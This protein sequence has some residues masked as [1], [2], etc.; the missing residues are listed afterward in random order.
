ML[1]EHGVGE[2]DD[3]VALVYLDHVKGM[4]SGKGSAS[5]ADRRRPDSRMRYIR[6]NDTRQIRHLLNRQFLLL[7]RQQ[8]IHNH[9]LPVRSIT[10]QPQ[11]TQRLLRRSL[12]AFD[13]AEFVREFNEQLSVRLT[14]E[15]RQGEDTGDVVV[16]CALFLL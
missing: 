4:T 14:L 13:L 1:F 7:G 9:L 2:A 8:Q 16:I 15:L 6:R 5:V 3:I 10:Q 12:N 11:I